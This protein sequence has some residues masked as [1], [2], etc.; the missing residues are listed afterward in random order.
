MTSDRFMTPF[1]I[2]ASANLFT[3][4]LSYTVQPKDKK[5]NHFHGTHKAGENTSS[6]SGLMSAFVHRENNFQSQAAVRRTI[7]LNGQNVFWMNSNRKNLIRFTQAILSLY[8]RR[9]HESQNERMKCAENNV[10]NF[11]FED[12]ETHSQLPTLSKRIKKKKKQNR[13]NPYRRSTQW[14]RTKRAIEHRINGSWYSNRDAFT[15]PSS[16]SKSLR[17]EYLYILDFWW[18]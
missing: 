7:A 10:A 18:R 16:S 13:L 14:A 6:V 11:R 2:S 17:F 4:T 8:V 12:F 1:H 9:I 5:N 3:C 15:S